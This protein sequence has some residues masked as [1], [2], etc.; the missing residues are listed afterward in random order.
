MLRLQRERRRMFKRIVYFLFTEKLTLY[1]ICFGA[2]G[3]IMWEADNLAWWLYSGIGP[4]FIVPWLLAV[5]VL[6]ARPLIRRGY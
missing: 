6:L 3:L 4:L 5:Y 1:P 2:F